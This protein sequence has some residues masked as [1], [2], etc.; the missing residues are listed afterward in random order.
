M[1]TQK[2]SLEREMEVLGFLIK[3]GRPLRLMEFDPL[4]ND[5]RARG[6]KDLFTLGRTTLKSAVM[7]AVKGKQIK[8]QRLLIGKRYIMFY[9]PTIRGIRTW[10]IWGGA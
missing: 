3:A 10:R 8:R 1:T 5:F 6:D 4:I 7:A 2:R 9:T